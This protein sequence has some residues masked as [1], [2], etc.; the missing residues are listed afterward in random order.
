MSGSKFNFLISESINELCLNL[1]KSE[2]HPIII[3]FDF[4]M[5]DCSKCNTEGFA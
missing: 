2:Y 4:V 1:N 5:V 3:V